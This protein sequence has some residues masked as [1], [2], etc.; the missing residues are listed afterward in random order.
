VT[1]DVSV[2]R[3]GDALCIRI[4][5][6]GWGFALDNDGRPLREGIGLANTR[7]RLEHI[8]GGAAT[9][10]LRNGAHGGAESIVRLPVLAEAEVAEGA[11]A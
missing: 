7:E 5:D 3:E 4:A 1:V 6:S 8:Y 9:L 10:Q 11:L 2:R